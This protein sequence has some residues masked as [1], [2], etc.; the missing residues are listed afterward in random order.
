MYM[1]FTFQSLDMLGAPFHLDTT[2]GVVNELTN[3]LDLPGSGALH[4]LFRLRTKLWSLD[5]IST[6]T[7]I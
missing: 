7:T 4:T 6:P 2:D 1:P 3:F 5:V